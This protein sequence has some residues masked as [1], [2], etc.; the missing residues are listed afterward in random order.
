MSKKFKKWLVLSLVVIALGCL[1]MVS[2]TYQGRLI[3]VRGEV[4]SDDTLIALSA[5]AGDFASKPSVAINLKSKSGVSKANYIELSFICQD[6][7]NGDASTF[8]YTVYAWRSANGPAYLVCNG[9]ATAGTQ[10][11]VLYPQ[12]GKAAT[13]RWWVDTL[14]CN[15]YW[16]KTIEL[17]VG[18]QNSL[19]TLAI[20]A[21]GYKWWAVYVTAMT[22]TNNVTVYGSTF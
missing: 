1:A 8:T 2:E 4:T 18:A 19:A 13:N 16:L 12:N 17:G 9:T 5:N 11:V 21:L 22:D 10:D 15:D 3:V 20:D 6:T 14:T 7:D